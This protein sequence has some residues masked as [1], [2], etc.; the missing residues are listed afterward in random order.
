[1][2]I[3][4]II[5]WWLWMPMDYPWIICW[6]PCKSKDIHWIVG[7]KFCLFWYNVGITLVRVLGIFGTMCCLFWCNFGVTL[8]RV[9]DE[10]G[11]TLGSLWNHFGGFLDKF[12]INANK[13]LWV[14]WVSSCGTISG[15]R[16]SKFCF[17]Y[18]DSTSWNSQK[19]LSILSQ[20][21]CQ[22]PASIFVSWRNRASDIFSDPL[23]YV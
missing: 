13:L 6:C 20:I 9:W 21:I 5:N 17:R 12:G 14:T 10:F 18:W 7:I 3:H 16:L 11:V 2:H 8:G 15:R 19:Y 4:R 22:F 23:R 1:M